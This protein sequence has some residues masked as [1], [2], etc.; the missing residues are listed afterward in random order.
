MEI[1]ASFGEREPERDSAEDAHV[2]A[3]SL[4]LDNCCFSLL[5][6]LS[7]RPP[8]PTVHAAC[9]S[10]SSSPCPF[11]YLNIS[12]RESTT[13]P[14]FRRQEV[15]LSSSSSNSPLTRPSLPPANGPLWPESQ[16][17]NPTQ[18]QPVSSGSVFFRPLGNHWLMS[19]R[20]GASHTSG[21]SSQRA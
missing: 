10:P 1:E 6:H 19:V 16:P 2:N 9:I 15:C 8:S 20:R 4:R 17:G 14:P 7:P 21:P 11:A 5:L 18:G 3:I 12:G 13:L